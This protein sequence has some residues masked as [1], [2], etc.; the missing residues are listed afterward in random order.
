MKS[1]RIGNDFTFLWKLHRGDAPEKLSQANNFSLTLYKRIFGRNGIEVPYS[2][3]DGNTIKVEITPEIA[4]INGNYYFKV[5]YDL[6]DSS[7]SDNEREVKRDV[8]A[9]QIVPRTFQSDDVYEVTVVTNILSSDTGV[10]VVK[11]PITKPK[12]ETLRRVRKGNDFIFKWRISRSEKPEEFSKASNIKLF[13]YC[14]RFGENKIEITDYRIRDGFVSIDITSEIAGNTGVY[15]YELHYD[16]VDFS[17]SSN[18]RECIVDVSAFQIVERTSH[19]DDVFKI[20]TSSSIDPTAN[21]EN[22][23]EAIEYI[24][25]QLDFD[26]K[27]LSKVNPDTA[28]GLIEFLQGIVTKRIKSPIFAPGLLGEGFI[29]DENGNAELDSLELR[30]SLSVPEIRFNRT[31]VYTGIRWDTFGAGKIKN[32]T[33]DTDANGDEL[34]SGIIE[35]ELEAGE[36]GAIDVDDMAMGVFHNFAASNDTISEDKRNGNFR[37]KGFSTVYFRI[38]EILEGDNSRFRYALRGISDNWKQQNHPQPYMHFACYANPSNTD[39]QSSSYTTTD[40]SIRLKN[41][42]TWEYGNNNIYE[43]S[44]KLDGFQIGDTILEGEGQAFGNAYIWGTLQKVYNDPVRMEINNGGDGFLALGETMTITCKVM[45][46]WED[47]TDTVET[48]TVTRETG[49]QT[50]DTAW[51]ITH[52]NFNGVLQITHT[53][54]YTDLGN[55]LSTLFVF[56]AKAGENTASLHLTI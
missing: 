27:Y 30:K 20:E 21:Y 5:G 24:L 49:N 12:A 34:Q 23:E 42:T 41:M 13:Q 36:F 33:I 18:K 17:L 45:R 46:G 8:A 38:T 3:I 37:F 10:E 54:E 53:K 15:Y 52:Q 1:V 31:T 9:F 47:I 25:S 55:D 51:N 35:L 56:T 40:Y 22:I 6:N 39:R 26:S 4:D 50:E 11:P 16:M 28:Q 19:A 2:I 7:L 29:I 43:I 48:W 32:V 14:K 44:G